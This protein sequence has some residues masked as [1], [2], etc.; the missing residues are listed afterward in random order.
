[1][2]RFLKIL[3][4]IGLWIVGGVVLVVL[5]VGAS[6]GVDALVGQGR[7]AALTNVTVPTLG[8]GPDVGVYLARPD[9]PGPHPAVI[10]IH[11]FW[12]LQSSIQGKADALAAEGYV[13][14][15]PDT[16][17][18]KS[19]SWL[20]RAILQTITT[21]VDD[22]NTDLDAVYAW[23]LTQ[24]DVIPDRILVMGFCYG[25]TKAL[26]YSLH[27][28]RLAG[29]GVFYGSGPITDPAQLARLP[30]PLLGIFGAEDTSIP[31]DEVA[32]FDA[33]LTDAGIPHEITIYPGVGHAFVAD[34]ATI[35][36]GGPAGD[37]WA[38]F[39]QFLRDNL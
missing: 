16:M 23:L 37:A 28:D 11:E 6:I 7:V 15:A 3:G 34:M 26:T 13:V 10:M 38:Q 33:G 36:A 31:L 18:G 20:P 21:P 19:T 4:R 5:L 1:M 39:L 17:R 12:G 25:G 30:G 8:A 9:S 2:N 32:A 27:N 22:V 24:P 35:Q 29:T 14:I